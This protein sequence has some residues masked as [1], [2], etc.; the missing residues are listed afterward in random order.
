MTTKLWNTYHRRPEE[1]LDESLKSLGL[2]YVDLYL[3]HWPLAMNQNGNHPL[4]PKLKNGKRD[5]DL[6]R[7]HTETWKDME[8]LPVTGK[9]KAIGVC[10]YSVKFMEELLK[11]SKTVPAVNQIENHPYLPQ[12]DIVGFCQKNG[13]IITAYSPFG[14]AGSP[15]FEEEGIKNVAEKHGTT[16]SAVLLSYGSKYHYDPNPNDNR[17]LTAVTVTRG[18]SVIPK[19]TKPS[20]IDENMRAV[21]LD[22]SDMEALNAI[23]IS[24]GTT[25]YVYPP[26]GFDFGFPD[27]Q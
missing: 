4:F 7:K 24:K 18:I 5:L 6:E 2:D 23:H 11:D 22:G 12:E 13:I 3:M 20:R 19:S 17:R 8:K 26:F 16:S 1:G 9:T 15:L 21:T 27:K 14:S 25:R 10:N